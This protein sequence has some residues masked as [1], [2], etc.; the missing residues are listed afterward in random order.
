M[1]SL[2]GPAH[3]ILKR[4]DLDLISCEIIPSQIPVPAMEKIKNEQLHVGRTL[5]GRRSV[6]SL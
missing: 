4:I 5:D 3:T 6:T 2:K 1:P